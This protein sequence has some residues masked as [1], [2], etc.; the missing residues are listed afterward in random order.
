MSAKAKTDW[1]WSDWLG[2]P[3]VRRL[4]PAEEGAHGH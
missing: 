2:D 3:G 1:F 4:T